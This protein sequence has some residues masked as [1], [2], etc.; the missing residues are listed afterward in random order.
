MGVTFALAEPTAI[1]AATVT[2]SDEV[3]T[4]PV[5]NLK[6]YMPF[7]RWRTNASVITPYLTIDFGAATPVRIIWLGYTNATSSATW[8]IRAATTEANLTADPVYDS[9]ILSHWP[10]YDLSSWN[11]THALLVLQ[12][13][14][15]YQWWRIDI[16]NVGGPYYESGRF[17]MS[18]PW[19]P[20]RGMDFGSSIGMVDSS[21]KVRSLGGVGYVKRR[22]VWREATFR[23]SSLSFNEVIHYA[24]PI[25]RIRRS[26]RDVLAIMKT[27][28][29]SVYMDRTLYG[30]FKEMPTSVARR[31]GLHR[32]LYTLE[33]VEYP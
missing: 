22:G 16:N 19:T 31:R 9:G 18:D 25:E 11:R 14:L 32:K 10:S 26:S 20:T 8:R 6:R 17:Y 24:E 23:F 28:E 12:G 1:D 21:P 30:Y 3:G 33:E 2:A 29:P 13:A 7:D 5:S 4:L 27:D 15:A